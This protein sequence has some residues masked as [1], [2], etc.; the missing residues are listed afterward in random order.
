MKWSR[1]DEEHLIRHL[2][3]QEPY[4]HRPPRWWAVLAICTLG[5]LVWDLI[6]VI[7]L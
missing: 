7:K 1:Q 5:V 4:P 2:N 3:G 6:I